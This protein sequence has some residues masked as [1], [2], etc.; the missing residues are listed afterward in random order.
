MAG[1]YIK[2]TGVDDLRAALR[3][4]DRKMR[5]KVLRNA[6][7]AAARVIQTDAKTKAPVLQTP[8]PKRN[9]GTVRRSIV[10]R[11]SR[12]ARRKNMVGVYVTVKASK[13]RKQKDARNDPFYF[14]FLEEGWI[15]RG[16]GHALKGSDRKK[17]AARAA[18]TARR[19]QYPFLGPALQAKST[20]AVQAFE[21]SVLPEI[22]KANKRK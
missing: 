11:A 13:A 3:D 22:A 15:P 12:L 18:S 6:L 8:T 9:P 21:Q 17:R 14:R 2:L 10:V 19:Y 5:F 16:P 7:R 4:L 20:Q 1:E